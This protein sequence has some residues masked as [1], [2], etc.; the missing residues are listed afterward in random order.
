MKWKPIPNTHYM[1]SDEGQVYSSRSNKI[2]LN[3]NR[4]I[5]R[6]EEVDIF[7]NDGKCHRMKV[8]RL[9]AELFLPNPQ[10]L[11]EINHIDGDKHN[12]SVSN[13][14]WCTRG[15]NIKHAYDHNLRTAK[16]SYN[17]N[18]KLTFEDVQYIRS[19]YVKGTG[20]HN[21]GTS[22]MLMDKFHITRAQVINIAK[23]KEWCYG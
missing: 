14:E 10:N 17:A 8:H 6:Y 11:K 9:V 1:V 22:K 23:G 16:G 19:H 21:R 13:L 2:L 18:A 5:N 4:N 12:N 20:S 3:M 7:D 15:Y